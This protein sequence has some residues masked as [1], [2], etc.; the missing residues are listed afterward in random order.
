[1]AGREAG[2]VGM[3]SPVFVIAG[4]MLV[5]LVMLIT[6]WFYDNR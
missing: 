6:G 1:M 5:W 3:C 2:S 4:L